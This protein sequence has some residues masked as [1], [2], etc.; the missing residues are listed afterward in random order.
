MRKA[1]VD[2]ARYLDLLTSTLFTAPVYR[3]YGVLIAEQR[4]K[5]A[6]FR[7]PLGLKDITLVLAA[8]QTSTTPMPLASL[9]H[10]HML[11]A[12]AQG[13]GEHDWSVVAALAAQNAGLVG[14][15]SS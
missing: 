3:T 5:P 14:A 6:G 15:A 2:P 7:L 12:L 8:A 13:Y 10:D 11:A 9:I 1:G 4:F